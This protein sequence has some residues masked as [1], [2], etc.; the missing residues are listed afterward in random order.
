MGVRP[1]GLPLGNWVRGSAR[2]D[3]SIPL[4]SCAV[5]RRSISARWPEVQRAAAERRKAGAE[6]HAGIDEV[7]A[8]HDALVAHALGI[9]GSAARPARG[10]AAP[11]RPCR[12][13]SRARA[14]SG[15][16]SFQT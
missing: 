1:L 7:G 5:P 13:A 3:A 8:L 16:P 12:R 2:A 4:P 9:R 10:R 11:A 14:F 15:L 6:D